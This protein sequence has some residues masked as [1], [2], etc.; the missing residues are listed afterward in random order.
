MFNRH[1]RLIWLIQ[2]VLRYF[3]WAVGCCTHRI[4]KGANGLSGW[5]LFLIVDSLSESS[6]YHRL[7]GW[8]LPLLV[9]ILVR[10]IV[11]F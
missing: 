2:F 4:P 3:S 5:V 11:H 1:I 10:I 6:N 8:I 7:G 9:A